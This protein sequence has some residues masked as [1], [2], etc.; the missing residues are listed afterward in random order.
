MMSSPESAKSMFRMMDHLIC[1][2]ASEMAQV[3]I[4]ATESHD[5]DGIKIIGNVAQQR[6]DSNPENALGVVKT[7]LE[8]LSTKITFFDLSGYKAISPLPRFFGEKYWSGLSGY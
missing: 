7:S 1:E 3:V 6:I 4:C 2:V 8:S 5:D